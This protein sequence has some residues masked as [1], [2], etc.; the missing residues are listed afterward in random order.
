LGE[1]KDLFEECQSK[2]YNVKFGFSRLQTPQRKGKL[3]R[4]FQTFFRRIREMLNGAG[5]NDQRKSG[6]W[7]NVQ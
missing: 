5:V 2:V 6:V 4:K 3:E 1:N 7:A